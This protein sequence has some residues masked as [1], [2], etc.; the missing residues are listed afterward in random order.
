MGV[1]RGDVGTSRYNTKNHVLRKCVQVSSNDQTNRGLK[2]EEYYKNGFAIFD[3][4]TFNQDL[5]G[6]RHINFA[7]RG[8]QDLYTKDYIYKT[9]LIKSPYFQVI[10]EK[11]RPYQI[12]L[13]NENKRKVTANNAFTL[14][15]SIVNKQNKPVEKYKYA[16]MECMISVSYVNKTFVKKDGMLYLSNTPAHLGGSQV[17]KLWSTDEVVFEKFKKGK[18]NATIIVLDSAAYLDLNIT[19]KKNTY[20]YDAF[21]NNAILK[22]VV[23]KG[24]G[25]FTFDYNTYNWDRA[26]KIVNLEVVDQEPQSLRIVPG[27]VIDKLQTLYFPITPTLQVELLDINNN[28]VTS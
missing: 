12:S 28:R 3:S 2:L 11:Y 6:K 15:M 4:L 18:A 23:D 24:N 1:E 21:P 20:N 25:K 26:T 16:N 17:S 19:L 8:G 10:S 9:L 7:T 13:T 5:N 22:T 14:E 27:Y